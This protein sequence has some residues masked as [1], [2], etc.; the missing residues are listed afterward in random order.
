MASVSDTTYTSFASPTT[1]AHC[2]VSFPIRGSD[3][4]GYTMTREVAMKFFSS[5]S[6]WCTVK[7]Y[8]YLPITW[9]FQFL[10]YVRYTKRR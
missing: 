7:A 1:G 5:V 3:D 8:V 2:G 6:F 10:N 4:G 9:L